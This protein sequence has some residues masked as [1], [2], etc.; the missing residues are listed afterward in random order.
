MDG[1]I[2]IGLRFD[3]IRKRKG[4]IIKIIALGNSAQNNNNKRSRRKFIIKSYY[5]RIKAHFPVD[6]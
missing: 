3:I 4:F 5:S 2:S 1:E 6:I